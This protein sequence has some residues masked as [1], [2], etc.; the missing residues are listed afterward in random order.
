MITIPRDQPPEVP[1]SIAVCPICGGSVVIDDIDEWTEDEQG[2]YPTDTGLHINCKTEPD[3][4][5]QAWED[6]FY[7]H[8]SMPYVD[9]LPL[10]PKVLKW[11]VENYRFCEPV[12][13]TRARLV[14]WNAGQARQVEA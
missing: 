5:G 13:E 9:W 10:Y 1:D 3:I 2:E 8:W 12:S 4:D 7:S 14:A 11:L 6:W